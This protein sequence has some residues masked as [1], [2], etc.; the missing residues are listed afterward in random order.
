MAKALVEQNYGD[1]WPFDHDKP[2]VEQ[3]YN[4]VVEEGKYENVDDADVCFILFYLIRSI[5]S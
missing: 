1:V 3:L 5:I 2:E 4:E